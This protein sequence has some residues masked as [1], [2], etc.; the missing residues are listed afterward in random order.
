MKE[1][2][3]WV[4]EHRC[5]D[6]IFDG[7][8]GYK[9][10]VHTLQNCKEV[11]V[12]TSPRLIEP[13]A[14]VWPIIKALFEGMLGRDAALRQ[15]DY[16]H[17]WIKVGVESLRFGD[18]GNWRAGHAM[19]M[20]GARGTGKGFVQEYILKPLLGGRIADPQ[21][22]LFGLDEYNTDCWG[23]ELLALSEI[24][25]PSQRMNDRVAF[26]EMIKQVVANPLQRMRVMRTDPWAL[27]PFWRL[28]ISLND[29][30]DKLRNFPPLTDD[31]VDKV[32]ILHC[33][34]QRMPMPTGTQAERKAF[35]VAVE[36]EVPHYLHWLLNEWAIPPDL[37]VYEDG[38]DAT[39]FGFAE[40]HHPIIKEGLFRDTTEAEM[41]DMIDVAEFSASG[42][43][44]WVGSKRLWELP[45]GWLNASDKEGT[46]HERAARL[47]QILTGETFCTSSVSLM[48]KKFFQHNR[49]EWA[50]ARL[51]ADNVYGEQGAHG[52]VSKADV[53]AWRG[54]RIVAPP[55][56]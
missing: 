14:G 43:D 35:Q 1:L 34:R 42:P 22:M 25:N 51:R 28:V 15:L 16:W 8:P 23:A 9:A 4:R 31:F 33:V 6:E 38:E 53:S 44:G 37:L 20:A 36:A 5:L 55:R 56:T 10:G 48:A 12:K 30:P 19:V 47:Q 17:S 40:F 24:P 3:L 7:L 41:L 32:I 50:L 54:W 46:W 18:P 26:C 13:V 27:Y 49:C 52:R 21:K 11:L 2:F 29:H 39:R 45:Q